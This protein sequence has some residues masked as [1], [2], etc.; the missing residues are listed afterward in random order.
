MRLM[1]ENVLLLKNVSFQSL[2][3]KNEPL[4]NVRPPRREETKERHFATCILAVYLSLTAH[5][6]PT[7]SLTYFKA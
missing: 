4:R 6:S 7:G 3:L 5:A 2:H 1:I